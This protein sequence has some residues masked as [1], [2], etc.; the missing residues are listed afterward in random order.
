VYP[1]QQNPDPGAVDGRTSAL[2]ILK[3]Y[4]CEL[5]FRRA[6]EVSKVTG[7]RGEPVEFRLDPRDVHIEWPDHEDDLH[8]PAVVML[9]TGEAQY[10]SIGLTPKAEEETRDVYAPGT[11][12]YW[13]SENTETFVLEVWANTKAERRALKAGLEVALVPVEQMYGLRFRV[14]EYFNEMVCFTLL[15]S[16]IV[17]DEMAVQGRRKLQLSIEMRFN[18]VALVNYVEMR[19]V[20]CTEIGPEVEVGPMVMP[21]NR[22]RDDPRLPREP[23]C[24]P[25]GATGAATGWPPSVYTGYGGGG[26][27]VGG[28]GDSGP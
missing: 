8:F 19:P 27:G 16:R 9:A 22:L 3:A 15:S 25:A 20:V 17:D 21:E 11:V 18:Q 10:A 13:M 6:G 4:L 5:T 24:V 2:R 1:P 26:W 28:W 23:G 14:P 12:L 7:K